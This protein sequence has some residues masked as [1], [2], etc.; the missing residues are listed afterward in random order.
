MSGL[1]YKTRNNTSP[2]G[3]PRVYFCCH[4]EDFD[5]FFDGVSEEIL[6]KQNCAVWTWRWTENGHLP[7]LPL[8]RKQICLRQWKS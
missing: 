4:P 5:K 2:Q 3:K 1:K 6:A 8:P 7:L